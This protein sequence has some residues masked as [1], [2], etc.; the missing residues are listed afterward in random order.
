MSS[1]APSTG[2]NGTGP[3]GIDKD[4]LLVLFC[5]TPIAGHMN[6]NL[7]IAQYL[8]SQGYDVTFLSSAL[9]EPLVDRTGA[10]FL[11]H[12]G[13]QN[14]SS[15]N[16]FQVFPELPHKTEG[17]EG[18]AWYAENLWISVMPSAAESVRQAL[19]ALRRRGGPGK[20][21]VIVCEAFFSGI[22]PFK[23]GAEL[24]EG[25][26]TGPKTL[27]TSI[28]P[29]TFASVD[30]G[31]M[32]PG[33]PFDNSLSGRARNILLANLFA[34]MS[35]FKEVNIHRDKMLRACGAKRTV[36]TLFNGHDKIIAPGLFDA[37]WVCHDTVLQ[38]CIPSLDYPYS[39][40]PP[41]AKW[42]GTLPVKPRDPDFKPPAW[43]HVII[44]N[45][46]TLGEA[47]QNKIIMVTQG[48]IEINYSHLIIPTLKALGERDDLIVVALLGSRG[49][50]LDS[51]IQ[52]VP[53]NAIVVDYFPYDE[54]L[55]HTDV[56]VTNA[57]YGVFSHSVANGVPAV[58]AGSSED[59]PEVAMRAERAG[60]AVNLGTGTPA[61]AAL[62]DAVEKILG[63]GRYKTRA[64]E[65]KREAEDFDALGTVEREMLAL[66]GRG[67]SK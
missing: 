15:H 47:R 62:G 8:V 34:A 25:F 2:D 12:L 19:A 44:A 59:K 28:L 24:P 39:D 22:L 38:M 45:S 36:E 1:S 60:F 14:Y 50:T 67:G 51:L 49:A 23:L 6:P 27:C 26:D 41:Y 66:V 35:P 11:P 17:F 56:L 63:D 9:N 32:G 30:T 18:F 48:T 29:A 53:E 16:I 20:E 40:W 42:G 61:P 54:L 3:S 33:L 55:P 64:M 31:P 43:F 13:L 46:S 4:N 52:A 65:L 10:H 5:C 7:Q 37:S 57:S 58:M 21:V